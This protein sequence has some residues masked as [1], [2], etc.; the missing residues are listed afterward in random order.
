MI[1]ELKY[2]KFE[3]QQNYLYISFNLK[4]INKN[5]DYKYQIFQTFLFI[6]SSAS[7]IYASVPFE[8]LS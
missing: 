8:R 7:D 3:V 6:N 1:I 5:D 2:K 4:N